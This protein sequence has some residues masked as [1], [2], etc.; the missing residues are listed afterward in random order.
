MQEWKQGG[1]GTF[2]KM[3][4]NFHSFFKP[5]KCKLNK[6]HV[7]KCILKIVTNLKEFNLIKT[8][9]RYTLFKIDIKS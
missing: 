2:C 9:Y 8:I 7:D 3:F 4:L 1:C 6:N 5:E